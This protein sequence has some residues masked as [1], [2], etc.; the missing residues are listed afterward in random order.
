M[1][2]IARYSSPRSSLLALAITAG[3]V[4]LLF[5][6]TFVTHPPATVPQQT[7]TMELDAT[8]QIQEIGERTSNYNLDYIFK[9]IEL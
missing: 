6:A 1:I 5:I 9:V 2:R 4:L 8:V 3:F 7:N